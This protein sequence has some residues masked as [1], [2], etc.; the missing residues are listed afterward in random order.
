[1][2]VIEHSSPVKRDV[3]A[4]VAINSFFLS[5]VMPCTASA[6]AEFG[7]SSITSTP[8]FSSQRRVITDPTSALF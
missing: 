6:T 4:P 2:P 7:T 3:A 1:M 5:R 8:S